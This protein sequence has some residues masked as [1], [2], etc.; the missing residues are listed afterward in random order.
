[1]HRIIVVLIPS[2]LVFYSILFALL[3][4]LCCAGCTCL[5][6][7]VD[8]FVDYQKKRWVDTIAKKL[9]DDFF[10]KQEKYRPY[11][12]YHWIHMWYWTHVFDIIR[13]DF[14]ISININYIVTDFI[15]E[16]N[17]HSISSLKA[18]QNL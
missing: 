13:K 4:P 14:V 9:K 12:V 10:F 11:I 6:C 2:L 7:V 5:P 3:V 16:C 18:F 8:I 1:M 15:H 17:L